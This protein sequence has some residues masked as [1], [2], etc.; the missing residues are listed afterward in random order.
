MSIETTSKQMEVMKAY[1]DGKLI[2]MQFR[3]GN[4]RDWRDVTVPTWNWPLI[5]YRVKVLPREFAVVIDKYGTVVGACTTPNGYVEVKDVKSTCY[6][7]TSVKVREVI[8]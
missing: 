6:P 7:L 8:E 5:A 3:T 1:V 4:D 2:E